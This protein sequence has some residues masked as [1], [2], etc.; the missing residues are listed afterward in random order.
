MVASFLFLLL[1]FFFLALLSWVSTF[2]REVLGSWKFPGSRC[3]FPP[4]TV[5]PKFREALLEGP[6]VMV[7]QFTPPPALVGGG[8]TWLQLPAKTAFSL[9]GERATRVRQEEI[10]GN[11]G[12][13]L[14]GADSTGCQEP[15][16]VAS[17]AWSGG[18]IKGRWEKWVLEMKLILQTASCNLNV[19]FKMNAFGVGRHHN[20]VMILQTLGPEAPK[21]QVW[22]PE[23]PQTRAYSLLEKN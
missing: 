2:Q 13:N 8:G 20:G 22:F 12:I 16:G 15:L 17:L 9:G 19:P 5:L 23:P 7:M 18:G 6:K 3:G 14:D 21:S 11:P 10:W 1:I 4:Y